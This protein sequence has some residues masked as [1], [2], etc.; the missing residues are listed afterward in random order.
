MTTNL[1]PTA[2]F[3]FQYMLLEYYKKLGL[4]ETELAV[5]FMI[6][7]LIQQQNTFIT[8]DMLSVK[9][10]LKTAEADQVLAALMSRQLIAYVPDNSSG[11]KVFR[12]SLEPLS[13]ILG[14]RFS[15][16]VA[17][18]NQNLHDLKRAESLSTLYSFFQTKWNKTLSPFDQQ[19]IN[20]FLDDGYAVVQ[21]QNAVEDCLQSGKKTT[22]SVGKRLREM[23]SADDIL[24]EG[25]SAVSET[26]DKDMEETLRILNA[27]WVPTDEN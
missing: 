12:M 7:H 16:D 22:K 3:D 8:A 9:M 11:Q 26:W 23:R 21:I 24:L 18:K 27:K 17:R 15:S 4:S 5:L 10:N 1:L 19:Q 25:A 13:K 2:G 14:Q 20:G 6:N